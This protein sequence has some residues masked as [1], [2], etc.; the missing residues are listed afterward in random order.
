MTI[1]TEA[2]QQISREEG[3]Y[4]R[5]TYFDK[6]RRIV[7]KVGSAVLTD[8]N[9]IDGSVIGNIARDLSFLKKKWS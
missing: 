4:L 6:A 7:V 8:E 9:G 5:Q 2:G 3:L 1:R